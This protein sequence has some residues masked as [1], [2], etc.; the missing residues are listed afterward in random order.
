MGNSNT[1]EAYDE[2]EGL[3]RAYLASAFV[4]KNLM[5][6]Y[7]DGNIVTVDSWPEKIILMKCA[8]KHEAEHYLDLV[9]RHFT[10]TRKWLFKFL[11]PGGEIQEQAK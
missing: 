1:S 5:V 8:S 10:Q 4:A 3:D 2:V 9:K 11:Y 6:Q 7:Y